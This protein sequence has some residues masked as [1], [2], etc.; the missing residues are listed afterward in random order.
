MSD[1]INQ[2]N[3]TR[4]SYDVDTDVDDTNP[5]DPN[6]P[7][8]PLNPLAGAD[9]LHLQTFDSGKISNK[10]SG[11]TRSA[12]QGGDPNTQEA[13]QIFQN[14]GIPGVT[15]QSVASTESKV[16]SD[17][18]LKSGVD[19][20]SDTINQMGNPSQ[21]P[22]AASAL[23]DS[24]T[25]LAQNSGID[26]WQLLVVSLKGAVRDQNDG[27]RDDLSKLQVLSKVSSQ[28]SQYSDVLQQA[29]QTLD[30]KMSAE[31][32]D[33][34][35][36]N[37]EVKFNDDRSYAGPDLDHL[38]SQGGVRYTQLA[39]QDPTHMADKDNSHNMVSASGLNVKI[40]N[41]SQERDQLQKNIDKGTQ[42]YQSDNENKNQVVAAITA[43]L[44]N[45]YDMMSSTVRN[46]DL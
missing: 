10:Y 8:S 33:K 35:K 44:K 17:P 29:Q 38:D 7:N 37:L 43:V 2:Y 14:A 12:G 32:D 27:L 6:N 5:N 46:M 30:N 25:Q 28:M 18:T 42:K 15:P 1:R 39:D 41:F 26:I 3:Q 4:Q 21:Q 36:Q 9:P 11:N 20:M 45:Y 23:Q 34:K 22:A 24:A 40:Q 13:L 16:S 31:K 19:Q